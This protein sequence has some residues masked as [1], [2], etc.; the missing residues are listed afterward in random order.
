M[1]G[2][3]FLKYYSPRSIFSINLLLNEKFLNSNL[4]FVYDIITNKVTQLNT[5]DVILAKQTPL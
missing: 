5:S 1:K 2:N 4:I 3:E